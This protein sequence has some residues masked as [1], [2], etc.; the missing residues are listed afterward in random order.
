MTDELRLPPQAIESEMAALGAMLQDKEAVNVALGVLSAEM[1]CKSQHRV[2]FQAIAEMVEKGTVVDIVTVQQYLTESNQL[3]SSGGIFYLTELIEKSFSAANIE[4]HCLEVL[5]RAQLRKIITIAGKLQASC[6]EAGAEPNTLGGEAAKE[7]LDL[8]A[9]GE[10]EFVPVSDSLQEVVEMIDAAREHKGKINGLTS[11]IHDLDV[12]T[13][14][15]QG[16]DLIIL[17]A[18]PGQGKTS[19]ALNIARH[20]V[21]QNI[22]VGM[23]SLEMREKKLI[24]RLVAME[25][26][27]DS[28]KAKLGELDDQDYARISRAVEKITAFPLYLDCSAGQNIAKMLSRIRSAVIKYRFRLVIIDYLQLI[29]VT[30]KYFNRNV[31]IGFLTSA[32]KNLAVDLNLPIMAL[33]QLSREIE[34][35]KFRLPILSDLRESGNIENDADAVMFISRPELSGLERYKLDKVDYNSKNL[36][37]LLLAKHRDGASNK[38]IPLQF[39]PE[40][41]EF[42]AIDQ[43][44]EEPLRHPDE[45]TYSRDDEDEEPF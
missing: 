11:G 5:K 28:T 12:I 14:G 1:F 44:Y 35:G 30:S 29:N 24:M 9:Y 45:P 34:K 39:I 6:Y 17:A 41:T 20:L 4:G 13:T 18:R 26:K 32:L 37:I 31:E 36:A 16:G 21:K 27:I 2:I 33:S 38:K 15:F 3:E 23:V 40:R 8:V 10:N 42:I 7:I 22:P 19:F 43:R 25:A